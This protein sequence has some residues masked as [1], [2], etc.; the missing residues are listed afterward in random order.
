M[1]PGRVERRIRGFLAR[2]RDRP[3]AG[4]AW[5]AIVLSA[6]AF[7]I[8]HLPAATAIYGGLTGDVVT[9]IVGANAVAGVGFGWLYWR[10]SLEAAMIAHGL[11][12]VVAVAA[13]TLLLLLP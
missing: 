9:F 5:A 8:G 12:H 3:G 13:W 10:H 2:S 1:I 11:A 6:V 7:G 4:V